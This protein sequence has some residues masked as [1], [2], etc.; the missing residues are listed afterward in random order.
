MIDPALGRLT[1]RKG[2]GVMPFH[3][4]TDQRQLAVL[5][6]VLN[7]ICLAAG[8]EPQ[9]P[10]SED[11]AGLLMH[12]HRIGYHTADELNAILEEVTRHAW[13]AEV[14]RGLST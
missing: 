7:E 1:P 13:R 9:S 4:I 8:I 11:A 3:E 12:L 2:I 5:I 10:E 6:A 14:P